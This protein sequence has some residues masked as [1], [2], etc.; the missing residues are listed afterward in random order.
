MKSAAVLAII[1]GTSAVFALPAPQKKTPVKKEPSAS[2]VYEAKFSS[3]N[4][5]SAYLNFTAAADGPGVLVHICIKGINASEP[6]AYPYHIH[7]FVVGPSDNCAATG[8]HLDPYIKGDTVPCDTAA[9]ETCQIG[10][11]SGKHGNVPI[12]AAGDGN[13]CTSYV[14]KY[15]S[16]DK[17][18]K[19][20]IGDSRSVVIHSSKKT[21]L[22]CG[23]IVL[24]SSEKSEK[25]T[26]A[27]TPKKSGK[28]KTP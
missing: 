6:G 3:S 16:L 8:T 26:I 24:A 5:E 7:N 12:T 4:V 22:A 9:P 25:P 13:Y 23:N 2:I 19:A 1:V 11:L 21:R 17:S 15:L 14:D 20:F 28:A 10:D 27:E 18:D